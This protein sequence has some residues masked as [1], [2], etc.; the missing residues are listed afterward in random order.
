MTM[1]QRNRTWVRVR[2]IFS[3]TAVMLI[4]ACVPNSGSVEETAIPCPDG[5]PIG[6]HVITINTETNK[7]PDPQKKKNVCRGDIVV[8][9]IAPPAPKVEFLLWFPGDNPMET[10]H[11]VS[12]AGKLV[13]V[14]RGDAPVGEYEYGILTTELNLVDPHIIVE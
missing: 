7:V 3:L 14:V 10:G 6:L 13:D 11:G 4:G 9:N 8:W 1:K 12:H 2:R 5:R